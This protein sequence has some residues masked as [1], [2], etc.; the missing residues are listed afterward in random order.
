M[1]PSFLPL[2]LLG[3]LP[4]ASCTKTSSSQQQGPAAAHDDDAHADSQGHEDEHA[5]LPRRVRLSD[6]VISEA[7]IATEPVTR[8]ALASFVELSGEIVADPDRQ[9]FVATRVPGRIERVLFREGDEVKKGQ[10]LAVVR[11]PELGE[12]RATYL[13]ASARAT[14]AKANAE[15]LRPLVESRF[16]SEQE[17]LAAETEAK[18]FEAEARAAAERL[19]ALGMPLPKAGDASSTLELRAPLDGVVVTRDAIVGQPVTADH[20]VATIVDLREVFFV[21]RVFEHALPRVRV[22]AR[23]EVELSALPDERFTGTLDYLG[24]RID[25]DARTVTARVVLS[26]EDRK[27]RLGLFGTARIQAEGDAAQSALVIPRDAITEIAGR[28]VA[29]VQ[30]ETGEFEAHDLELGASSVGQV[31]VLSGLREGE[32]VVVK[33]VFTLKSAVLRGTIEEDHH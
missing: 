22:G 32:K 21:A 5:P 11:A 17:L 18:S 23:A 26:N 15:R 20:S 9:A 29:F 13:S 6:K 30:T 3:L 33:G 25:P 16:A 12:L 10:L 2:L 14:A 8:R 7:G 24:P 27:L 19:T 31:E 1:K 28:K 4:L